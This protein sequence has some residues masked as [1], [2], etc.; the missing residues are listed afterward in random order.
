M[1]EDMFDVLLYLFEKYISEYPHILPEKPEALTDALE[2]A[3]F[4][5][6]SINKAFVWLEGLIELQTLESHHHPKKNHSIRI[7]NAEEQARLGETGIGFI[8][9]LE[10][11]HIIDTHSRELIMDRLLALENFKIDLEQ[12]KWVTL[13][14]LYHKHQDKNELE[15]IEEILLLDNTSETL[16]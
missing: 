9:F 15:M 8:I 13:I 3:G 11:H 7:F 2:D 1:K 5:N 12:V 6:T 14:V 16:H 4:K 10:E